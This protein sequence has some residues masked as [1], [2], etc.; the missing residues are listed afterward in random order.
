MSVFTMYKS[1]KSTAKKIKQYKP[2][3]PRKVAKK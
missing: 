2:G 3:N 1:K